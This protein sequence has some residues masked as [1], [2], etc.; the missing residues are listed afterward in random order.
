[1]ETA[2]VAN[3]EGWSWRPAVGTGNSSWWQ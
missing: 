3:G 1:L 2:D